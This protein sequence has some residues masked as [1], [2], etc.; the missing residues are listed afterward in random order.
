M[1][2]LA[3][4]T[5]KFL[6][7]AMVVLVLGQIKVS[8]QRICDHVARVVQHAHIQHP[9]RWIAAHFKFTEGYRPPVAGR[10]EAVASQKAANVNAD[11]DAGEHSDSDKGHLSGLLKR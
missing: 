10:A 2:R 1:I 11:A 8:E 6:A 7:I 9:I 3:M 4:T 5:L